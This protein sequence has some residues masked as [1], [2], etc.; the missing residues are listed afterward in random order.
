MQKDTH[1]ETLPPLEEIFTVKTANEWLRMSKKRPV[2][3]MLFGEFWLEG[4][5]AILFADTG[6]G[7]SILAVQIAEWIARGR[8]LAPLQMNAP[9]QTV[10][11]LD[12]ELSDKQFEMRYA[13]EHDAERGQFLRNHYRFSEKFRRV[14]IDL[15]AEVP[16]GFRSF[17]DYLHNSIERLLRETKAKVLIVDNITYLKRSNESTREALPLM[18]ELKRLKKELGLSILV[19]AHTPKRAN[20][21]PISVND[22]QGSKVLSNFADNIFAIGE[23]KLDASGR[24]IKQIKPRS[25]EMIYDASHVPSFR[26]ARLGGNFLGF[27]YRSFE[28]ESELLVD[29]LDEAEWE[30]IERIKKMSDG[31]MTIRAI[32]AELE[33][34]KSAVHRKLQMWKPPRENVSSRDVAKATASTQPF[35]PTQKFGYFPG[36]EEY[37]EASD[38]PRFDDNFENEDDSSY[39]LRR[40]SCMIEKARADAHKEYK[41]TGKAPRLKDHPEYSHFIK[42]IADNA[43]DGDTSGLTLDLYDSQAEIEDIDDASLAEES[44]NPKPGLKR[45]IDGYGREI[46]IESEDANGKPMIWYQYDSK[47]N[48]FRHE[49]KGFAVIG[50]R[51]E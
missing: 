27:E 32:A 22:L 49:R 44:E 33:M 40:E 7:K 24:Y 5:L 2:P 23:S 14:E 6:K 3:K 47:G 15:N 34:S 28:P 21:R 31:E 42:W 50:E 18:K 38:D 48:K 46:F 45:S 13:G 11:Y 37:D 29:T 19:L 12:F 8:T 26:I 4:E 1:I 30:L 10:L 39:L 9:P 41:R 25:T 51:V 43:P 17:D 36:C 16:E 20:H 35:D